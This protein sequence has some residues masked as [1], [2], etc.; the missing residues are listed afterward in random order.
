MHHDFG[1]KEL[2]ETLSSLGFSINYDEVRKFNTSVA[3]DQLSCPT[4][5]YIPRGISKVV[6]ENPGSIVDAAI[7]N[8]DRN[9]ET[10]DGKHTTHSMAVVLYQRSHVPDEDISIPRMKQKSLD[11]TQCAE[12]R[13]QWYRKPPKKP[14]P[15]IALSSVDREERNECR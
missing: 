4:D 15:T 14:E 2:I 10:V 5:V 13:I 11:S 6:D 12:D 7:D 1:S 3:V 8:F 9:E